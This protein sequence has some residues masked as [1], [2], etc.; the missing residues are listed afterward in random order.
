M[1]EHFVIH[2]ESQALVDCW[3]CGVRYLIPQVLNDAAL[4]QRGP[5]GAKSI[6]CPNGHI[7][8]YIGESEADK[9]R[10]ERDQLKQDAARLEEEMR[11]ARAQANAHLARA[12]KAEAEAARITK[13]AT[14]GVCP[15]CSR[16]FRQL[17]AHMKN[18]HP[19][20]V[21]IKAGRRWRDG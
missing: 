17:A 10:R 9:L 18:K 14:A 16:S 1:T 6:Y 15:C 13:R 8:H 5:L 7:W 11:A 4:E 20:V 2:G 21:P 19:D 12:Q 3:E